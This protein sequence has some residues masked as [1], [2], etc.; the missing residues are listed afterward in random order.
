LPT[1]MCISGTLRD[2]WRPSEHSPSLT[3]NDPLSKWLDLNCSW[4][5]FGSLRRLSVLY[6]WEL[7]VKE[8]VRIGALCLDCGPDC[9]LDDEDSSLSEH[10]SN[11][12][13][14]SG[15]SSSR[16]GLLLPRRK[17][18]LQFR[19]P[20]DVGAVVCSSG[21]MVPSMRLALARLFSDSSSLDLLRMRCFSYIPNRF[22]G[23]TTPTILK[24]YS[25]S[26]AKMV[27]KASNQQKGIKSKL[28]ENV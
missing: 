8:L 25:E 12:P 9:L 2:V 17:I 22:G 20:R 5:I 15:I 7:E 24:K 16:M 10:V 28:K 19:W 23:T 6:S 11:S 18:D 3:V 27:R 1:A 21:D 14:D 26:H 13:V 4:S